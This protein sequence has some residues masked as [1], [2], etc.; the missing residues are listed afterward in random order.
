V[1]FAVLALAW[2]ILGARAV[3]LEDQATAVIDKARAG[4]VSDAEARR[5]RERLDQARDLSPDHGPLIKV[6]QLALA[7]GHENQAALLAGAVIVEEP[8]NLQGWFL[9]WISSP[10]GRAKAVAERHLLELNPWFSEVLRRLE[11]QSQ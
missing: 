7:L 4:P 11:L 5:A 2:L 6:G 10:E 8:D 1:A 3:R 9:A